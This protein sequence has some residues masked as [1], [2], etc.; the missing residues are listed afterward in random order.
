MSLRLKANPAYWR[1]LNRSWRL[2]SLHDRLL[3]RAARV[4]PTGLPL[5]VEAELRDDLEKDTQ[6]LEVFLG[7]KLTEWERSSPRAG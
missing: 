4:P 3:T 6:A 1:A 7:R 2:C 5:D